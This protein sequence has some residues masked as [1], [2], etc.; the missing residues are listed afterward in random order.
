VRDLWPESAVALGFLEHPVPIAMSRWLER[1]LYRS[2]AAIVVLTRGIE[3]GVLAGGGTPE[4]IRFVPN[5]VD[6]RWREKLR[7]ARGYAREGAGGQGT[8]ALYLGT[9]NASYDFDLILAAA[10][11]L[12]RVSFRFVGG[13]DRR[14]A[15]E[16]KAQGLGNVTFLPPIPHER[17]PQLLAGVD[18]GLVPLRDNPLFQG[19]LPLKVFELMAAAKP[20]VAS[21]PA[22]ELS[23]LIEESG[24]GIA[25]PPGDPS[26]FIA[27]IDQLLEHPEKAEE[28]G[29]KGEAYVFEHHTRQRLVEP[30]VSTIAALTHRS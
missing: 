8:V 20:I 15:V 4:Q 21:V 26:P 24:G 27:A 25:V 13:G 18:M 5:G 12:P 3:R 11:A 22:G 6:R 28:M 9:I 23:L 7:Q 1:A 2:A 10:R 14:E 16:R 29:R 19:T 30:L 17:L